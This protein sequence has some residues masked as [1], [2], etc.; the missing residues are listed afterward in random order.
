LV[1]VVN[2]LEDG[3]EVLEGRAEGGLCL[4]TVL[5]EKI[6]LGKEKPGM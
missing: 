3:Y 6:N 1:L 4:P 2:H 5:H